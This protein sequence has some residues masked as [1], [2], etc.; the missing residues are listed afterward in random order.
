M[1]YIDVD[2][3]WLNLVRGTSKAFSSG[4]CNE[5]GLTHETDCANTITTYRGEVTRIS[6]VCNGM[7]AYFSK[8]FVVDPVSHLPS[9]IIFM[10]LVNLCCTEI[11][12]DVSR[13]RGYGLY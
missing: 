10:L 5:Y 9:F 7:S 2:I 12:F 8:P 13:G 1:I 11:N 3:M 6:F 4:V